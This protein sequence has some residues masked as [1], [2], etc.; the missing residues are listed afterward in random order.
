MTCQID[1]EPLGRRISCP[2]GTTIFEAARTAGI[3]LSTICGG[4]QTCGRC[5]IKVISGSVSA[6]KESERT[7]LSEEEINEGFRLACATQ[8]LGRLKLYIPVASLLDIHYLQPDD[9]QSKT[10]REP[11]VSV[12]HSVK[13]SGQSSSTPE[14]ELKYLQK[15]LKRLSKLENLT[16]TGSALVNIQ[17][18]MQNSE[19]FVNILVRKNEV[20]GI[21]PCNRKIL[22]MAI[23]LGSSTLVGSLID[24]DTGEAFTRQT[25]MNPQVSYGDDVMSRISFAMEGNGDILRKTALEAIDN[26]ITEA[27]NDPEEIAGIAICGNTAMHHLLLG[28]PVR[29]LGTAPY[30]PAVCHSMQIAARDLHLPVAPEAA[31]YFLPNM[32]G[33]IGGDHVAM[34]LATGIDKTDKNVIGIDIGTNTE[35]TLATKNTLTGLSCAS[36]PAFE[37]AGISHGMRAISGAIDRVIIDGNGIHTNVINDGKPIGI[38]GSGIIDTLSE[39]RRLHII[40]RR[41]VLAENPRVRRVARGHEFVLAAGDITGTGRDIVVT[42]RDIGKIQLAKAAIRAGIDILLGNVGLRENEI[43]EIIVA[44][45]FGYG[46]NLCSAIN[47]GLFPPMPEDRFKQVG[48]AAAEGARLTL[49]SEKARHTAEEIVQRV[50]YIELTT[51]PE[52]TRQFS[53]ALRFP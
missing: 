1:F 20:I 18:V 32:A 51:H 6:L 47:V 25:M 40:N 26:L 39:L 33:F 19:S 16:A 8:V 48:N 28:L 23:D 31:V 24:M 21:Y 17:K 52:F 53:H 10:A 13:L 42:Q 50:N 35:I 14:F 45:T 9:Q 46:L 27:V 44:G 34:I 4:K 30:R 36:G 37:G 15:E 22:G 43:D 41:G 2:E 7:H 3:F 12:V 49:F 38:C 29:Q 11:K 5:K